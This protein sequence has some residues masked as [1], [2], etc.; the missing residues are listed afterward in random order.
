MAINATVTRRE[1]GGWNFT[2]DVGTAPYAIWLDGKLLDTVDDEEY[3]VTLPG[4]E[5]VP[6]SLEIL[7]DGEEAESELYPPYVIVQ[8][9]G[10][11]T[12]VAYVVEE[13]VE[14]DWVTRATVQEARRGYYTWRS[15][16]KPDGSALQFRVLPADLYGNTGTAIAF[17]M[18]L[19]RNP[20]TP[21]IEITI[22][23]GGDVVVSEE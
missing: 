23:D 5:D 21:E 4:Y 19:C 10:I 22:N 6:P 8:W 16:A 13:N 2:W 1:D 9:R 14:G 20:E 17:S 3:D 15:P 12:A 7:N 18:D 11:P